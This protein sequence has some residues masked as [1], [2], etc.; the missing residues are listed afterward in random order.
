M[1]ILIPK[2][3]IEVNVVEAKKIENQFCAETFY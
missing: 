3:E 2:L 1:R